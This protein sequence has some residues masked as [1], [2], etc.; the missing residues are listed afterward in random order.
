MSNKGICSYSDKG[1]ITLTTGLWSWGR[2]HTHFPMEAKAKH[3]ALPSPR[4]GHFHEKKDMLRKEEN[5]VEQVSRSNVRYKEEPALEVEEE[6]Q[7][8]INNLRYLANDI[9]H[10]G[11]LRMSREK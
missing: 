4:G 3:S 9:W 11:A 5:F 1:K 6:G 7:L 10:G 2:H 8:H